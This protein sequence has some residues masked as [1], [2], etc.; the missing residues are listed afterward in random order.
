MKKND[1]CCG[2]CI[3]KIKLKISI[4]TETQTFLFCFSI[5]LI[6]SSRISK[7]HCFHNRQQFRI[8]KQKRIAF[9]FMWS[10]SVDVNHSAIVLIVMQ[11]KLKVVTVMWSF[12]TVL[13]ILNRLV[14]AKE[15]SASARYKSEYETPI[16]RINGRGFHTHIIEQGDLLIRKTCFCVPTKKCKLFYSVKLAE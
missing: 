5:C 6:W 4:V 11:K 3:F 12:L 14:N 10:P 16:K 9:S 2:I 13:A 7:F 1:Y 8:L 15:A